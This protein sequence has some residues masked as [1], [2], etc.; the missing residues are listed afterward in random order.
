MAYLNRATLIGNLGHD[1]EIRTNPQ[2]GRK[3]VT[4]TLATSK[5][6]REANGETKEI[7]I[8]HNEDEGGWHM[9]MSKKDKMPTYEEMK[10]MRY[11]MLPN[12]IYACE[13]FP[14]REEFVNRH[15]FCRH[16]WEM[17]KDEI[18]REQFI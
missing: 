9:S 14:P 11:K 13:I 16:L 1:P 5:R 18:K 15:P 12:R 17:P 4:F 8:W 10:D 3:C 6:F 2:N 7:T